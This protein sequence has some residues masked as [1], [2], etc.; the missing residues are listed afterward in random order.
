MTKPGSFSAPLLALLLW[1]LGEVAEACSCA[2]AHPQQA[3]CNADVVIRAKVIGQ[4][5]VL[6]GSDTYG[7]P[8]KKIQYDIKQMKMFKG[9]S[10]EI[11]AIFTAPTSAVCGVTLESDGK[12]EYL[13][14][15]KL[16]SDG[17][18]HVTLCDFIVPWNSLTPAQR[19]GFEVRYETGCGCR[20]VRCSSV[21]CSV[22]DPV[23]CLWTDWIT[24]STVQGPQAQHYT[25]IK[26]NDDSCAWYRG[27][28]LPKNEFM[29]IEDP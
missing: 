19:K 28:A 24:Q 4:K 21:P 10:Q 15:G 17:T 18:V 11:N 3:H 2:P 16:E 12:S 1:R 8:I 14:T 27:A 22:S 7:N 5:E 13:V 29:D 25:C 26:R 23:E 9:P 6:I 20:I